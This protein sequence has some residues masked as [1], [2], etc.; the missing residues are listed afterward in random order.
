MEQGVIDHYRV[1][2]LPSG[3]EGAKLTAK[4]ISKA[5]K[6]K[7]LELHP[8]KRRDDPNAHASFQKLKSSY[9][10]LKDEKARKLFDDLLR[11]K[12]EKELRQTQSD[13]KRQKL[14]SDLE[15]REKAAFTPGQDAKAQ[16]EEERIK[17]KLQEEIA[18]IR[19]MHNSNRG[20]FAKEETMMEESEYM[21]G[22]GGGGLD[23]EKVLKVSWD[24]VGGDYNADRL[25]K[26][27]QRFGE[28]ED[29]V[30]RSSKKKGSALV[31]MASKEAAV[32]ATGSMSG[33]L[34][35]PLLVLSLK[36]SS[37][38]TSPCAQKPVEP[39]GPT[40][41][42]LIGARYQAFENSVLEKLRKAAEKQ[43]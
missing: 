5:Y 21:D 12:R 32:V 35:N 25:R 26:L 20:A 1:L 42:N 2:G 36:P 40:T 13:T 19:A 34:S 9:E 16:E 28:V 14:V 31:V 24:K 11:I 22:N 33:D 6:V 41:G 37:I 4:E 18:R 10:I 43:K 29:V 8:D 30:I 27:F 7:A 23:N 15:K 39:D 17:K 3:D 38:N